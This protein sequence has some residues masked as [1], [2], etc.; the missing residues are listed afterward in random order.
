MEVKNNLRDKIMF[1]IN[2]VD[3]EKILELL[4]K[5]AKAGYELGGEHK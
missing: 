2:H 1:Y 3:D 4:L 5:Y